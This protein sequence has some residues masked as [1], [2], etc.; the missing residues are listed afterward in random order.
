MRKVDSSGDLDT[1]TREELDFELS[2]SRDELERFYLFHEVLGYVMKFETISEMKAVRDFCKI[3]YEGQYLKNWGFLYG[4]RDNICTIA[5]NLA[6]SQQV[7]LLNRFAAAMI[8]ILQHEV[9]DGKGKPFLEG[10]I[11]NQTLYEYLQP[12]YDARNAKQNQKEGKEE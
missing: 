3:L 7:D 12:I 11:G 5:D 2:E 1:M 8:D 4:A 10:V 9:K 6:D